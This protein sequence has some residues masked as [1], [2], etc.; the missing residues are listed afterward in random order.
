MSAIAS[1]ETTR[2]FAAKFTLL[3]FLA[4]VAMLFAAFTASYVIRRTAADWRLVELPKILWANTAVIALSSVTIEVARRRASQ[5]W[6]VGTA[7]LGV[8]FLLG[9][10]AGWSALAERGVFLPSQPH[11]SFIYLLTAIHGVHLAGGLVALGF[12]LA[13]RGAIDLCAIYWHFLGLV[14]LY[15]LVVLALL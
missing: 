13:K 8:L 7:I 5:V 12:L 11:A 10:L 14:W 9:Q 1:A 6:L 2:R 3:A 15:V 4:T